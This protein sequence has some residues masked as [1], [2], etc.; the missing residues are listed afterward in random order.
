MAFLTTMSGC[1]ESKTDYDSEPHNDGQ[2]DTSQTDSAIEEIMST[3]DGIQCNQHKNNIKDSS[4]GE[5]V[6]GKLTEFSCEAGPNNQEMNVHVTTTTSRSSSVAS[7]E[8]DSISKYSSMSENSNKQRLKSMSSGEITSPVPH[9]H[10]KNF[11]YRQG[12]TW[13]AGAKLEAMDFMKKW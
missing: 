5:T 10:N 2:E 7:S 6:L 13:I 3:E 11:P 4:P 8:R 1:G 9:D 12:I